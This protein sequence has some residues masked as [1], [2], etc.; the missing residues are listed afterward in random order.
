MLTDLNALATE[1]GSAATATG[2]EGWPCERRTELLP[3]PHR[4][5]QLPPGF[6]AVYVFALGSA[7]GA[8]TP[9]GVG[10]VFNVG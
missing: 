10:T 3:A 6:G 7:Y 2:I 8:T 5:P 4:H 9:A 1:F